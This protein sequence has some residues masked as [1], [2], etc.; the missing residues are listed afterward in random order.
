M[1]FFGKVLIFFSLLFQG[2]VLEG[3]GDYVRNFMISVREER[4]EKRWQRH[5]K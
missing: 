1:L 2:R 4:E 5:K 3:L